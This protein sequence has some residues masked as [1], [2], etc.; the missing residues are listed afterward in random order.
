[1]VS[2]AVNPGYAALCTGDLGVSHAKKYVFGG[3]CQVDVR[4]VGRLTDILL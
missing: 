1:M 3:F 2:D 4:F